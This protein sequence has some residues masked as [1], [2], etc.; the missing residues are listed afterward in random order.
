MSL[1]GTGLV[2]L[3]LYLCVLVVLTLLARRASLR[4]PSEFY[5]GGRDLA[6]FVLFFTLYATT[7]S[8]NSLLGYPGEAYR[9]GFSW[10]MS[11]GF[12]M[13]IM[14]VFLLLAPRLRRASEEHH[15]VSPGDYIRLRYG[16][17]ALVRLIGAIQALALTQFLLAQLIAMGHVAAGLTGGAIPYAAG[18][19]GLAAVILIYE[20]LGGLRA[21]AF[22]DAF[23]GLLLLFGLIAML[24]WLLERSGGMAGVTGWILMNEPSLATVPS[25]DECRN[26]ASSLLL[27]GVGS[28]VYPQTIQRIYAARSKQTLYRSLAL[29]A[30]MPL[31]TVFVVTLVGIAA[32]PMLAGL[33]EIGADEVMPMV[34][35]NWA[36]QG[37]VHVVL[38]TLV[39]IGALAAIMSTADSVLLSLGSVISEDVVGSDRYDPRTT[40]QGKLAA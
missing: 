23:Q 19:I 10:V 17:T 13:A 38:A 33:G 21:V 8:G 9:R 40:R 15:L 24:V 4:T 1:A 25:G 28:V 27:L 32:L 16:N 39:F 30:W 6:F 31:V 11:T 37:G 36:D 20:T 14:V 7:Y 35:R 34:I 22:T 12:M 2:A 18:V 26:W 5:L 3:G 29:M